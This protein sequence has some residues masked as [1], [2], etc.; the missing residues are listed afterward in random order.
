MTRLAVPLSSLEGPG[1]TVN[2]H[3][4]MS[5]DFAILEAE[6]DRIVSIE[7]AHN[8]KANDTKAAEFVA[9]KGVEVVL[10]GRIGSC[11]AR[12]FHDRGIKIFCG[13]EGTVEEAFKQYVAGRLMEV[14]PNPYQL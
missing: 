10:A 12:I 6:G 4:A 8:E 7:F 11:M 9:D 5:E 3:F 1:S 14:S 2:D 13:A